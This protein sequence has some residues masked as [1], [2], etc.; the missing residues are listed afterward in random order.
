M[1]SFKMFGLSLVATLAFASA[2]A[3]AAD[4]E[5]QQCIRLSAIDQT[6][7]IDNK[8]ILVEKCNFQPNWHC[9][10]VPVEKM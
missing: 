2:L 4:G 9:S 7:V 10:Y 3:L 6:P 8:T 1:T 5:E